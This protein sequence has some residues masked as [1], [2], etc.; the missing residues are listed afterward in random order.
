MQIYGREL[1][2]RHAID[3]ELSVGRALT[4]SLVL[5][6][7]AVSRQHALLFLR[8]DRCWLTDLGSTNGT[9]VND[10]PLAGETPLRHGDLITIGSVV[11]KF[12]TGNNAESQY[13][14]EIYRLT[15]ID[16]LTQVHNRRYLEDFLDREVTRCKRSGGA[17]TLAL[18][19]VDN[20]KDL[21]DEHG[22]LFG[23]R[24]LKHIV[25]KVESTVRRE[26]LLARYGGDEFAVVLTDTEI[27]GAKV[28]AEK[29][30]GLVSAEPLETADGQ[31]VRITLSI[32][33]AS[34]QPDVDS[35]GLVSQADDALYQA[36]RAGRDRVFCFED[37]MP[38]EDT[39]GPDPT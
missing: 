5:D 33:L 34:F 24:V 27:D 12:I 36:K 9:L 29:V 17:L 1:G 28:F 4:N 7:D 8:N 19:D 21:N 3:P 20:F 30:R 14:E 15:I 22:H 37:G 38:V 32:G 16:G 31:T 2:K 39:S 23:D 26:Q 35:L 18:F 11:F 10:V 6:D 25:R 13:Y